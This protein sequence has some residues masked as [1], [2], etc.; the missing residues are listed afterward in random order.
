M[1]SKLI[2]N[3]KKKILFLIII[4]FNCS[5]VDPASLI[6]KNAGLIPDVIDKEI[7]GD[8][9]IYDKTKYTKTHDNITVICKI[10]GSFEISPSNH[11]NGEG[12]PKCNNSKLE[13]E[14]RL[15]LE[16]KEI[17]YIFRERKIV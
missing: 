14:I 7:H 1:N 13:E 8:K 2:R 10:H 3:I 16:K 4:M 9:Y 6:F 12:C 5:F 11:L 17:K 15:L